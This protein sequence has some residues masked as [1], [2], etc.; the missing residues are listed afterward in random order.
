MCV[1]V[2]VYVCVCVCVCVGGLKHQLSDDVMDSNFQ[3]DY[4]SE[5][6]LNTVISHMSYF[7]L[8]RYF[9]INVVIIQ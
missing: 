6:A 9:N 8:V 7:Y 1:C 3:V 4:I 2:C 5:L